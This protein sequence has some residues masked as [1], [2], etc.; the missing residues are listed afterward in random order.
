MIFSKDTDI[1]KEYINNEIELCQLNTSLNQM[2]IAASS[3]KR[4]RRSDC[5]NS[6]SKLRK[7]DY[8]DSNIN[9]IQLQNLGK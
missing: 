2:V 8:M 4:T 5:I 9:L 6:P 3:P 1:D 7:T